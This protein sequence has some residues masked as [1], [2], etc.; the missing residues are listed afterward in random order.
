[1][2]RDMSTVCSAFLA[3]QFFGWSPGSAVLAG[4]L[5]YRPPVPGLPVSLPIPWVAP[6][7]FK[8]PVSLP[9]LR[10]VPYPLPVLGMVPR[11]PKGQS[12]C[13]PA[14][15]RLPASSWVGRPLV[16]L[17]N[18][19]IFFHRGVVALVEVG[20]ICCLLSGPKPR[21]KNAHASA[22]ACEHALHVHTQKHLRMHS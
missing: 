17:K 20:N 13:S 9:V 12:H 16:L 21:Q 1:L 15:D 11:S 7:G 18:P 2:R 5:G 3:G 19:A 6:A 14:C 4:F 8:G 10:L 22:C